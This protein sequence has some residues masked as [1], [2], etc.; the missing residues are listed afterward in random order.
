M[1]KA[2]VALLVYVCVFLAPLARPA[3][4]GDLDLLKLVPSVARSAAPTC[5]G[6]VVY[7]M[8]DGTLHL[9]QATAGANPVNISELLDLQYGAGADARINISP[10]GQWLVLETERFDANCRGWACLAVL[11][12][13]L[14]CADTPLP[15]GQPLHIEGYPAIASGGQRIVYPYGE[16]THTLDLWMTEKSG[17]AWSKPVEI[18]SQS[19]YAYNGQPAFSVNGEKVVFNCSNGSIGQEGTAICEVNAD[20]SGYRMIIAPENVNAMYHPDYDP[21]GGVVFEGDWHGE[22]I[23]RLAPGAEN[24]QLLNSAYSNDN[25]PCVLPDG[26]VVSLW[27]QREGNP[28]GWHEIKVMDLDGGNPEMLLTGLDVLDAG[29]GCGR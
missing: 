9:L 5:T 16:G 4:A 13:D 21:E 17:G 23:Y 1:K 6:H 28:E 19:A 12:V 18:T 8:P 7:H 14:S 3:L 10:D 25:S 22:A 24:P 20:G 26:R 29:L 2:V 15:D 11:P 27:L